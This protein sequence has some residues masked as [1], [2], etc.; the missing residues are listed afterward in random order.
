MEKI[1]QIKSMKDNQSDYQYWSSKSYQ[2]RI[3][4]VEMLRLQYLQFLKYNKPE[5]VQPRLQR[6]YRIT[7]Q[8]Q[9]DR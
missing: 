6:V 2:A 1:L 9:K 3:E 4:A 7:K 5:Y 8:K